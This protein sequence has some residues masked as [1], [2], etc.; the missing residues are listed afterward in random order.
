M[1]AL[2]CANGEPTLLVEKGVGTG[3]V[4][5][6]MCRI[7]P[8]GDQVQKGV[9]KSAGASLTAGCLQLTN[10]SAN[11]FSPQMVSTTRAE[12]FSPAAPAWDAQSVPPPNSPQSAPPAPG[13]HPQRGECSSAPRR[14][15]KSNPGNNGD[16]R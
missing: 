9:Q 8:W 11:R 15:C 16:I 7:W 14:G 10:N 1:P 2:G 12:Q 3:C 6:H 4:H 13:S 5:V